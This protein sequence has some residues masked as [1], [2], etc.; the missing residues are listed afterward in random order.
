MI[1]GIKQDIQDTRTEFTQSLAALCGSM[2]KKFQ[3][4]DSHLVNIKYDLTKNMED[5]VNDRLL[6]VKDVHYRAEFLNLK[7]STTNRA[8]ITERAIWR[9]MESLLIYQMTYQMKIA[10]I[11]ASLAITPFS[12]CQASEQENL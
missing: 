4:I 7:L 11:W 1:E 5:I 9:F 3:N 10:T 2:D 6:K 8:S 12:A